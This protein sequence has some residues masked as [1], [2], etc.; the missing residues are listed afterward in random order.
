MEKE[1]TE[2]RTDGT[3]IFLLVMAALNLIYGIAVRAIHTTH[4]SF[5][6]WIMIAAFFIILYL[7]RRYGI[8]KRV[9]KAVRIIVIVILISGLI[10]FTL[11]EGF[12]LSG[13]DP[14]PDKDLDYIV[15]LGAKIYG[16]EPSPSLRYRLDAAADYMEDNTDTVCILSGGKGDDEEY[17]EASV[18][19]SYMKEKG[20]DPSRLVTEDRSLSTNENLVFSLDIIGDPEKSTGI[21]TNNYHVARSVLTAKRLGYRHPSGIAAKAPAAFIPHNMLKEF[22]SLIKLFLLG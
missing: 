4:I 12:V 13:F 8:W 18:M 14:T 1:R 22:L 3:G 16:D 5:I 20:I 6:L 19:L 21:V 17:T 2:K 10:L 15:V 7:I 9:P 11:A